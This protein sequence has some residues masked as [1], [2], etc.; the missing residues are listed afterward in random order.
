MCEAKALIAWRTMPR[1]PRPVR[2]S[3]QERE[4]LAVQH[5]RR[6]LDCA[7]KS[8]LQ[9]IKAMMVQKFSWP[10]NH[11]VDIKRFPDYMQVVSEPMD[12]GTMKD[13]AE[14]GQYRDPQQ[15]YGD[16]MLVFS[17]S[18]LYN[19]PG[20]DVYYMATVLQE[21]FLEQWKKMVGPKL[22][23][24]ARQSAAEEA[25]M[26]ARKLAAVRAEEEKEMQ[27]AACRLV[28]ALDD[29]H[30][31][32]SAIRVEAA[33]ACEPLGPEERED[34]ARRLDGLTG[35][36][37]EAALGLV[38][39]QMMPHLASSSLDSRQEVEVDLGRCSALELRQ[40][41]SFVG[42][43]DKA[44]AA[45]AARAGAGVDG[46]GAA[47]TASEPAPASQQHQQQ[48]A[49]DMVPTGGGRELSGFPAGMLREHSLSEH[50]AVMWPGTVVGA[51]LKARNVT[52]LPGGLSRADEIPAPAVPVAR[53]AVPGG[54]A[55]KAD[56]AGGA[57]A[58]VAAGAAAQGGLP[59][60]PAKVS[61]ARRFSD[62]GTSALRPPLP[63]QRSRLGQPPT[64][65]HG[66]GLQHGHGTPGQSH[67]QHHARQSPFASPAAAAHTPGDAHHHHHHQHAG[68]G[69]LQNMAS[70][71]GSNYSAGGARV[72]QQ[73]RPHAGATGVAP[74]AS[75]VVAAT[76]A[77][78]A[79][80]GAGYAQPARGIGSGG[81][82]A[83]AGPP[84]TAGVVLRA[85]GE[86]GDEVDMLS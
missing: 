30:E 28:A 62:T 26:A 53:G 38:L 58:P 67:S 80:G 42:A 47:I 16:F 7:G 4:V 11:P 13:K 14:R 79:A 36:Q 84:S 40:L 20:S 2:L 61:T 12:F 82:S 3:A 73:Q 33:L 32:L 75:A 31:Q 43:C 25:T 34:L 50:A 71:Q 9:V 76:G 54:G 44:A 70:V 83:A 21:A 17:N 74:D 72:Q 48:Q 55:S 60:P 1:H 78:A 86:S 35:R 37:L 22:Q 56:P 52:L 51:G 66:S 8:C 15:V 68:D 29:L 85:H 18:R 81:G 10:F 65:T 19:P 41:Q 64:P 23:E 59:P 6:L 24:C 46:N 5:N 39:P 57:G 27:D 45:A 63:P 77:A 49:G 69:P